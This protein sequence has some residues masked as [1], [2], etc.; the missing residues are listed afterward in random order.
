MQVANYVVV[1]TACIV[2]IFVI[3]GLALKTEEITYAIKHPAPLIYGLVAI[4]GVTPC[5]AFVTIRLPLHPAEFVIGALFT[6]ELFGCTKSGDGLLVMLLQMLPFLLHTA[7]PFQ[8][9]NKV[10]A[11][12]GQ[13]RN[14]AA[15]AKSAPVFKFPEIQVC[16][17]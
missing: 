16:K 3:S 5:L 15:S 8:T 12:L 13:R 7:I 1:E 10:A 4:L 6:L 17:G 2:V 14:L 11:A 9:S